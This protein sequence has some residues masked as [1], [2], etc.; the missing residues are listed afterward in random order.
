M[1]LVSSIIE[2]DVMLNGNVLS[3][4][5]ELLPFLESHDDLTNLCVVLE[6]DAQGI[7]IRS[8]RF[9]IRWIVKSIRVVE[10]GAVYT[11]S[12]FDLCTR[13]DL[14]RQLQEDMDEVEAQVEA[15]IEE[16]KA[17]IQS[18]RDF[19]SKARGLLQDAE[20]I[21]CLDSPE[22]EKEWASKTES[23]SRLVRNYQRGRS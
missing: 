22:A 20:G 1:A 8:K 18:L 2:P 10:E 12:P 17:K 19:T 11:D 16:L 7:Y 6:I 9:G 4:F 13:L 23:L 21:G 3:G 5:C 14:N 15:E